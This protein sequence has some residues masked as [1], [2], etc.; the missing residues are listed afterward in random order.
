MYFLKEIRYGQAYDII[1]KL[2]HADGKWFYVQTDFVQP[3]RHRA[4]GHSTHDHR[5][6]KQHH[7][8]VYAT[9]ISKMVFKARSGKTIPPCEVL[10]ALG[11]GPAEQWRVKPSPIPSPGTQGGGAHTT[12]PGFWLDDR[13]GKVHGSSATVDTTTAGQHDSPGSSSSTPIDLPWPGL[14]M[15]LLLDSLCVRLSGSLPVSAHAAKARAEA[16]LH[17][18]QGKTK[19]A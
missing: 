8:T 12:E 14:G 16:Q 3:I 7:P 19:A 9:G 11:Y 4:R 2:S 1:T 6:G 13:D 18:A 17:A 15:G 10:E 5:A